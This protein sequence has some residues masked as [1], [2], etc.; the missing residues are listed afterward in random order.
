MLDL[1]SYPLTS[2]LPIH[3]DLDSLPHLLGPWSSGPHISIARRAAS[4]S[5]PG[6]YDKLSLQHGGEK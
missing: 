5:A 4:I 6:L 2:E 3:G 1:G